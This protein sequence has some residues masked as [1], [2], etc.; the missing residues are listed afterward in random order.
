MGTTSF[1]A[2]ERSPERVLWR[3][4]FS[5][6]ESGPLD[7]P[8]TPGNL[9]CQRQEQLVQSLLGKKV[10]HQ[11]RPAFDQDHITTTNIPDRLENSPGVERTR[12][13]KNAD[14][15]GWWETLCA[16]RGRDE[17]RRNLTRLKHW[18][19]K[20]NLSPRGHDDIKWRLCLAQAGP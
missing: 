1:D 3:K 9:R 11:L 15:H 5:H 14:L 7:L 2:D 19:L 10:T 12:A 20:I 18:Q 4:T 13:L 6:D 17:Q 16:V 8:I